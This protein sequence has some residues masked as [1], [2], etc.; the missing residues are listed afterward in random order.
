MVAAAEPAQQL[1]QIGLV[2]AHQALE[3]GPIAAPGG[4]G[5]AAGPG[6]SLYVLDGWTGKVRKYA[7]TPY[8]TPDVTETWGAL[9]ARYR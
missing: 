7:Y 3:A 6:Y 8:A 5:I 4:R 1:A 9:K 2:R